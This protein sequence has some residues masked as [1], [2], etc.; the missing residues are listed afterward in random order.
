MESGVSPLGTTSTI[1]AFTTGKLA[2]NAKL[3]AGTVD[4]EKS[5]GAG[6]S[7]AQ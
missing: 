1:G 3:T 2:H 7:G 4:F 5:A 6:E